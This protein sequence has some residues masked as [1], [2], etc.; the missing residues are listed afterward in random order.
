VLNAVIKFSLRHRPLIVAACLVALFYGGYQTTAMPIDVFPDLDRPR[1]TIMTECPGLAPEE[2]ET[3]VTYPLES[4]MLGATGVQDV[5]TQSGFGLSV[6]YVEFAWGTDIKTARQTVQER[7]ATVAGD[8]P[9]DVR[10]QMAPVSSIMGQILIAG[11]RRQLGPKGG[12]LVPVPDTPY[13]AERVSGTGGPGLFAW[14]ATDRKNPA[15]WEAVPVAEVK[16]GEITPDG[17]Q[18]VRASVAGRSRDLVFPSEAKKALALRTLADWVVRPR[19]LKVSGVSQVITLGGGRKQYQV[20][21]DP[22]ALHEYRV[23][24]P[25]VESALKA[26][27]VNFTGG[28]AELSGTEKPIRVIGRL[29]PRPEQVVADLKLI[30]VKPPTKPE[31]GQPP[32]RA[33]LL[34]DVA[35]V[36]EGAQVRRGD[37]AI[38]GEPGVALT[39]LKQPHTDTRELTDRAKAA[40]AE[41]EQSLP[42]DVI[43]EPGLYELRDFIDRGVSNVAE[44]LAIGAVLVLL[45][46]FLFLLNLRTTFISLTAIPISLAVTVIVFQLIGALT[47]TEL[48]INVMTL[49][50]IAVAMGELVDDA[51]VD[52]ENIFRRLRENN[53]SPNPRPALRVVYEASVEVRTS[54]VFGTAVVILVFLPLFALSGIEGRLFTPLGIAYIV[55]ILASLAVSLTVTPVLSSYLLAHSKAVHRDRD[56][57]LL[58]V[59]KWCAAH[60]VRF[61]MRWIRP[62]LVVT[63]LLVVYCAWRLTTIGADFLPPFDEGAVQL[64]TTLPAGTSLEATTRTNRIVD[65][66]LEAMR[67]TPANPNGL[68]R[69]FVRKTGRAELDE[70]ADPP[71]QSDI[72]IQLN[73]DSG[74]ARAET[75]KTIHD[76]VLDVTP[77]IEAEIEQPLAHLMSETISGT[78]AQ[79]AIKV[80]GDDLDTLEKLANQVRAAIAGVP[81]VSS[82]VVEPLRRTDEIHIRLRPESLAYYGVDR[83]HVGNFVQTAL[84]GEVVSQVVEGQRRFDLVVRLDEP[85]RADVAQLK[86]LWLDL[87]NGQGRVRLKDL[88]D[89]TPMTGGDAGANQVKRE[90]VRR[91]IIVRCNAT[92]R[93]LA[94]VVG[95]IQKNVTE[96]VPM[97]E[98]YFVEYGGQFESQRRA[99]RLI[100]VLAAVSVVGMFFVLT[101]LFPSWR[102]VTQL[103][104]SIPTA[105]VGGVLAL[106]VTGQTLTVA[107]LVGFISLGG[108]AVRNGV[109]L[110]T[111]YVHLMRHEGEG[112]TEQMILRGSLERLAPVLMTALTAGIALVPLVVAG[113]QPGREILYPVATVILGGLLTST[114]C[115]F[116]LRPG[117]FWRFSGNDATRLARSEKHDDGLD[118]PRPPGG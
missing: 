62:L 89:V 107:S 60:L 52:V 7:L 44:A 16:W 98:G 73:P 103:L 47:G 2:V 58:R 81:G 37:A 106:V 18:R 77:G 43:I 74:V 33:V 113:N 50:G 102:I 82:L 53:H 90:N 101:M 23:T 54:I 118:G 32:G 28:F 20:L 78:K 15:A 41:V 75:L 114:F 48:S 92:G 97:P 1:V 13:Y 69:S 96:K 27:N 26:N 51:I 71:N 6:V 63:L 56:G 21:V 72:I 94:S 67:Q 39:I 85:Y 99:T 10:P 88:A 61:S 17:D 36:V 11:M 45:I 70:H 91:R 80:F 109:L 29:G 19:L 22:T 76:R 57:L 3:L 9:R 31:P 115:E 116:L 59:L 86:E 108:I 112:F 55:S 83:A 95:D 46:L 93:D 111:H 38:N 100:A 79:I 42:A 110:V 25:D 5:R 66:E 12:E 117:L 104:L 64:S 8:L 40:L 4:S 35:K 68:I 14:K 49:G 87:P 105:F 30:V 34:G 24:L 65:A 84:N